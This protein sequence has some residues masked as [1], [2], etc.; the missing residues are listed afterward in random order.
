MT[1]PSSS[2]RITYK[3]HGYY[4]YFYLSVHIL[5]LFVLLHNEVSRS[6]STC[7]F[8]FYSL[9]FSFFIVVISTEHAINTTEWEFKNTWIHIWHSFGAFNIV[10]CCVMF[11]IKIKAF[12]THTH[13]V[14]AIRCCRI[15][16]DASLLIVVNFS[17]SL[18]VVRTVTTE[19]FPANAYVFF[20][21]S[22]SS[23][24]FFNGFKVRIRK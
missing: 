6:F 7:S 2:I 15:Q 21:S 17:G 14:H 18:F 8:F 12:D 16:S 10:K 1:H 23:L 11:L 9:F 5:L 3:H 4:C 20:F 24:F 19:Y 22:S 13:F